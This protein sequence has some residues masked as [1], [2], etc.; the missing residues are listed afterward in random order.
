MVTITIPTA[1]DAVPAQDYIAVVDLVNRLNLAFD[2]W[3]VDAMVEAF[4]VDAVLEHPRGGV[5]GHDGLRSFYA[6]YKPVTVGVKRHHLNHVVDSNP[7]G[8]VTVTS[9]NLLIR[10]ASPEQAEKIAAATQVNDETGL[11]AMVTHSLMEDRLRR[12]PERGWRIIHR[13]V[14]T[15]VRNAAMAGH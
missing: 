10:I 4:D 9:Y 11:P 6:N 3:D 5:R 13:R 8:T 7:D 12:F 2:V 1:S 14:G 15:T